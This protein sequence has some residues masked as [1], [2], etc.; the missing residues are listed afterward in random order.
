MSIRTIGL[1]TRALV[2]RELLTSLRR[3][4]TFSLFGLVMLGCIIYYSSLFSTINNFMQLRQVGTMLFVGFSATLYGIAT[5]ILPLTGAVSISSEKQ[6]RSFDLLAMTYLGANGILLGK[7]INGLG[8]FFL[9]FLGLMPL[10]GVQFFFVGIDTWQFLTTLSLLLLYAIIFTLI[11][12][13][14]SARFFRPLPALM[15]TIIAVG[16]LNFWTFS[17]VIMEEV[18]NLRWVNLLEIE[19]FLIATIPLARSSP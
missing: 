2:R 14:M 17:I 6:Q 8:I 13:N 5:I 19:E 16:I 9:M 7:L 12:L 10:V 3:H 4:R 1:P 11:G 18:F 15:F